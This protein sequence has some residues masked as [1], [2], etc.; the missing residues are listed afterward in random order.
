MHVFSY[1]SFL[2]LITVLDNGRANTLT[3]AMR[4]LMNSGRLVISDVVNSGDRATFIVRDVYSHLM[5]DIRNVSFLLDNLYDYALERVKQARS[6][7][8]G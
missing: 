2:V 8:W 7:P 5:D 4:N 6:A 1:T 3:P